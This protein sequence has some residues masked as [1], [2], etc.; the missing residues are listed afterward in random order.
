[1]PV[2][3]DSDSYAT[4]LT[5]FTDVTVILYVVNG[6]RLV[7]VAVRDELETDKLVLSPVMLRFRHVT[8]NESIRPSGIDQLKS[9]ELI[10]VSVRDKLTTGFGAINSKI[11][12][13]IDRKVKQFKFDTY[14]RHN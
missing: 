6:T 10:K 7:Q 4:E 11:D 14:Q 5:S 2:I 9:N 12:H 3:V 13:K 8:R 1:M